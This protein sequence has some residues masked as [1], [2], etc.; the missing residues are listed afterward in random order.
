MN[1]PKI[2]LIEFS[3]SQI[4]DVKYFY[5]ELLTICVITT[6]SNHKC[7]GKSCA[8]DPDKYDKMLGQQYAYK[9]AFDNLVESCSFHIRTITSN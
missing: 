4:K 3:E 2:N 8:F 6:I 9:D 7:I 1:L 5:D